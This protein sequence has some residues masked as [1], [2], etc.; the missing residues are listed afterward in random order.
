MEKL[1]AIIDVETTGG[2]AKKDKV[3]EFAVA[4]HDGSK[5]VDTYETLIHPERHIPYYITGIT[6]INNEM[7]RQAPRFFEVAKKIVELTENSIFVAHNAH[8][9]YGFIREEFNA[10]GYPF[11]KKYLDTVRL[12]RESFPGLRSYSLDSLIRYFGIKVS[13]RHRAMADVLA[14]VKV[15][16]YILE[17]K[18]QLNF[19][20]TSPG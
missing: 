2:S 9:D 10:L 8:F 17:A 1:F 19:N 7:V 5:I 20:L 11:S 3:I 16:E 18:Q 13:D 4:L 14:T 12:S 6:G 15:F